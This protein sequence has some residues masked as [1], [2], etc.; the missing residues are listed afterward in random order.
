LEEWHSGDLTGWLGR[1]LVKDARARASVFPITFFGLYLLAYLAWILNAVRHTR[2]YGWMIA[3]YAFIFG[4]GVMAFGLLRRVYRRQDELLNASITGRER[5]FVERDKAPALA[6]RW[7]LEER[8]QILSSLTLRA[9]AE[10]YLLQN[11][12]DQ[13]HRP[14]GVSM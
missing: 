14:L 2:D 13:E 5:G 11:P 1:G 7:Y 10:M 3:F 4:T 8:L 12:S 9:A 6:V